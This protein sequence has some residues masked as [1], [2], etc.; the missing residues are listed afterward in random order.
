MLEQQAMKGGRGCMP[1]LPFNFVVKFL[2]CLKMTAITLDLAVFVL[3]VVLIL[4]AT[5]LE[6]LR[7]V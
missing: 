6:K 5:S 7:V 4:S 2:I 3:V 1:S